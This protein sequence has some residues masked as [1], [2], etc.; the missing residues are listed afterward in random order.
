MRSARGITV[1]RTERAYVSWIRRFILFHQKRHPKEMAA[2][3]VARFVAHLATAGR[4][5]APTQ[6]QAL[7][8]ILFLYRNVLQI[9]LELERMPQGQVLDG[10]CRWFWP[11]PRSRPYSAAVGGSDAG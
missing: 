4:V 2:S 5:S 3:E 10:V 6:R 7:S 8:A 1:P 9:E 11:A